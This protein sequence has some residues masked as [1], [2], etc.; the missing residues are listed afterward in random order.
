MSITPFVRVRPLLPK[1][2]RGTIR[3]RLLGLSW[4]GVLAFGINYQVASQARR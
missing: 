4:V 3:R 2:G 1:R